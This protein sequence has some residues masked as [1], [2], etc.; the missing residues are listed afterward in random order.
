MPNAAIVVLK[1]VIRS[2]SCVLV[3]AQRARSCGAV[4]VDQA[5]EVVVGLGRP[6]SASAT[7]AVPFSARL[8]VA[9]RVVE[10]LGGGLAARA[11][12]SA[13]ASSAAVGLEFRRRRRARRAGPL[14]VLAR[15]S[16]WSAVSTWSSCTGV[17][18]WVTG[19]VSPSSM[20]R[21]RRRARREVDEEVALEEDAR[22]DLRRSR[23]CGSAARS[24]SSPSS[25]RRRRCPPARSIFLT[26]PTF[27]A[28]DPHRRVRADR[29]RRLEHRLDLGSRA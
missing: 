13:S 12:G 14:Q 8:A 5:R 6:R 17:A 18:V 19:I 2:C 15:V 1:F 26:L 25:R 4:P 16:L 20:R 22:A 24:W 10:R 21:R 23:P 29:V 28:G 11:D 27:D 7:I 3:A 9:E